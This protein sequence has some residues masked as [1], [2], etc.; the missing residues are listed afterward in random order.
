[1]TLAGGNNITL[2]QNGNHVTILGAA[3]GTGAGIFGIAG[4]NAS[5][6]TSGTVQ[7]ANS[8]G[9]T[10]GL[11]GNTITGSYTVPVT[12]SFTGGV[13]SGGNTLGT[14]GTVSNGILFV[15]GT[16]L[17]LSQSS[18]AGG[19]TITFI[20]PAPGTT[21]SVQ[22][23]GLFQATVG[24]NITSGGAGFIMLSSGTVTLAGGANI[25]LSQAGNAVT[26]SGPDPSF[27]AGMSTA[28]NTTGGSGMVQSLLLFVGG[29]NIT[30]S[31][32]HLVNSATITIVGP[33]F[34]DQEVPTGAL[35]GTNTTYQ[36]AHAPNPAP[37]LMLHLNG[38]LLASSFDYTLNSVSIT[39]A[40]VFSSNDILRAWY[41]Y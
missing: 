40:S 2:S 9:L 36:L 16:N 39:A 30:L 3:G 26:I 35:N 23:Q 6:A 18:G 29:N 1:M 24:G 13:S 38:Q 28:G 17:T 4:S 37:C 32:S 21:Q 11:N 14:T 7:F 15:G 5:T 8:N 10:F 12:N 20:G 33:S 41:R 27:S 25:T 34:A 31:G 22:T 19:A